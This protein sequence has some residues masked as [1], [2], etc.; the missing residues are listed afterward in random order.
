[1]FNLTS[2]TFDLIAA[3]VVYAALVA[4]VVGCG[5]DA[6]RAQID[7]RKYQS[8]RDTICQ[9]FD[10]AEITRCDRATFHVL[11]AA[12]CG[13]S[14]PTKY[15][16]PPGKWNR[17]VEKCYPEE[18]RSETS[19]DTYLSVVLG[20]DQAANRR[21]IDYAQDRGWETGEPI[22]GVGN[23][24]PL[25]PILRSANL[26]EASDTVIDEGIEA[27]KKA[28]EGHRGHLIAGYLWQVARLRGHLTWIGQSLLHK[29]SDQTPESPYLRC[30]YYR[31][32]GRADDMADVGRLLDQ[33][34]HKENTFG[35]GSSPWQVHFALTVSCLEGK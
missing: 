5:E 33:I 9:Y 20:N 3:I 7:L 26:A 6:G 29:I 11:M 12:A 16:F 2:K 13:Q 1:M 18:S 32:A 31:F 4:M 35:W 25:V 10:P 22:G 21:V 30:L 15:E 24:A 27:A 8:E 23:I 14:L 19:R 17:D 28:F 34:P